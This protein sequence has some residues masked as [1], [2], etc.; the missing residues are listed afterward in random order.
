VSR[1]VRQRARTIRFLVMD[2]DGVLTDGAIVCGPDGR[3]WKTFHVHDGFAITAGQRAGLRMALISGRTSEAVARRA[4]ELGLAEVHQGSR[5]KVATYDG[6]LR[7]HGLTDSAAAFVGDDLVDLP[8]LR[9][10]GLAV[11]VADAAPEVRAA[12]HYVTAAPGGRG[13]VREVIRLILE[14]QG[15][16]GEV[17]HRFDG[18]GE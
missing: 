14:A 13:A 12:A 9:R 1:G 6:L 17:L 18:T 5:D 8:L 3:E 4:A 15:R 16:W 10:V 11:A 7:R 2:V